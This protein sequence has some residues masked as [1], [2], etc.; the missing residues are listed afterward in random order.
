MRNHASQKA[1]MSMVSL[2]GSPNHNTSQLKC[3]VAVVPV[4]Q[5]ENSQLPFKEI[6]SM[7]IRDTTFVTF[8]I[9]LRAI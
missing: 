9:L 6:H 5:D 2:A 8:T 1:A 4:K 7:I 3:T